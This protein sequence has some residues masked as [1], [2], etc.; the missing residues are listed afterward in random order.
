[1]LCLSFAGERI[2]FDLLLYIFEPELVEWNR[3]D[4]PQ[5]VSSRSQ[6]YRDCARHYDR[7]KNRFVAVAIHYNNVTAGYGRVPNDLVGRRGSIGY[8][9]TVVSTKNS[10]SVAF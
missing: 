8:K 6:E 9:E 5:V 3:A 2:G 7:M 1:M 10:R 4:D